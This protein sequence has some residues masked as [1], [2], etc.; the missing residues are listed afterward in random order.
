MRGGQEASQSPSLAV[1]GASPAPFLQNGNGRPWVRAGRASRA[2]L[3]SEQKS[4]PA[5]SRRSTQRKS[6]E[7]QGSGKWGVRETEDCTARE[8][9]G[10]T[11]GQNEKGG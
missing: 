2:L 11:M 10:E 3:C 7:E 5:L 9:K 4:Y 6:A 8:E 1:A